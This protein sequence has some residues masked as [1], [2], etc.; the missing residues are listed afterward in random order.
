M[1][2]LLVYSPWDLQFIQALT[3]SPYLH[4]SIFPM[5]ICPNRPF[6]KNT[7]FSH[8]PSSSNIVSWPFSLGKSLL[9]RIYRQTRALSPLGLVP[10]FTHSFLIRN[11][12]LCF[13]YKILIPI[14]YLEGSVQGDDSDKRKLM[15]HIKQ[16][17]QTAHSFLLQHPL[18]TTQPFI[19][20]FWS[21]SPFLL[22]WFRMVNAL[23]WNPNRDKL[24][25]LR[26]Y[27]FSWKAL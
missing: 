10:I 2:F 8:F 7:G 17:G 18:Q 1:C 20:R 25:A 6:L 19:F 22:V 11:L 27:K 12:P 15:M 3:C 14:P 23:L 4:T 26:A 24:R 21:C 9:S 5:P 16:R 13:T